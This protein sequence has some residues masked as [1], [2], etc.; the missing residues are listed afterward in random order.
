[1]FQL[2][3]MTILL[4]INKPTGFTTNYNPFYLDTILNKLNDN[5]SD[6]ITSNDLQIWKI[7]NVAEDIFKWIFFKKNK[8][9]FD[10]NITELGS[11]RSDSK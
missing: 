2:A 7:N 5:K 9:N 8:L 3:A 6:S 10:F 1:M 11:L 4:L